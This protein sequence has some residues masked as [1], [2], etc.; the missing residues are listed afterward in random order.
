MEENMRYCCPRNFKV[1]ELVPE[2]VYVV[3]GDL[4]L[5]L[6]DSRILW[7]IDAIRDYYQKSITVNNWADGGPFDQRGF[8]NDPTMLA[9]APLSQHNCGRAIDLDV[10]GVPAEEVR[11]DIQA[12]KLAYQV[13]YVTGIELAV[14]WLHI[15][16]GNRAGA[17]ITYFRAA[18]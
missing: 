9:K 13:A 18:S 1:Q 7:T 11:S 16:V 5:F 12:G 15:D 6:M 8:R 4:S 2:S 3:H 17:G 10:D 14:N